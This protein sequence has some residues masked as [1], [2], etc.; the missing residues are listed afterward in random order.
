M[1][2]NAEGG[3]VRRLHRTL[4]AAGLEIAKAE[5]DAEQFGASTAAALGAFQRQRGLR[6]TGE[7]DQITLR[8]LLRIEQTINI[9]IYEGTPAPPP[10]PSQVGTVHGKL[11]EGDGA[12]IAEARISL[13]SVQVRQEQHLADARTDGNGL[14]RMQY[15]RP[16]PLSLV[17]RAL[18]QAGAVIAASQPVFRADADIEVD[19]TTAKDGVVR[20][21]SQFT[22]L[23]SSVK[24]ALKD[25]SLLDLKEN[26]ETHELSFLAQQIGVTFNQLADLYIAESLARD[27]DLRP[28]TLFG[29]FIRGTPPNLQSALNNLP[30]AGIDGAFIAQVFKSV[31]NVRSATLGNTLTA[32]VTAN[33]LPASYADLQS[34]QLARLDAL[35][36]S[37]VGTTPYVRGKTP[38]NDLLHT[39]EVVS[40]VQTAFVQAYAQNSGNLGPTWKALRADK[41]LSKQDLATLN[42]VLS[43]GELLTGNLPL[44]KDTLQRLKQGS[45]TSVRD[46]ALLDEADWEARIR[47]LD[48]GATTIPQVLPNDTP[49]D[50]IARF[51]KALAQRFA[52]RYP[53]TAFVGGMTKA[54]TSSFRQ[55]S[56]LV[57]FLGANATFSFRKSNIDQFIAS[58]KLQISAPAL[59]ELK[60]AQRL[61]RLAPHYPAVEALHAA[62]YTSAQSIYFTGRDRF[63]AQMGKPMGSDARARQAYARAQMAY[64]TALSTFGRYTLLSQGPQ[65]AGMATPKPDPQKL[66]SLPDL[67]ALFGSLDYFQSEDCQSVYS[68]AAY[69]VDLLQ[70]ISWFS[71]TPLPGS[72]PPVSTIANA[73][74]AVLLRRPDIEHVALSCNNTNVVIPYIDLVNEILESAVAPSAIARPT[75]VD[76]QGTTAE[77]RAL[78]QQTQP[79]VAAAAYQATGSVIFPLGLPF[80]LDFARTTAYV[81]GLGTS[82]AALL[83]LFPPAASATAVACANLKINPA[84]QAVIDSADAATPWVR[85]GFAQHP[86]SV[87]DPK[88]GEAYSPNPADWVATL[89]KVPVLLNRSSL[90]LQQLYQLLEVIWVTRSAVTLQAG[91]TTIAGVQVLSADTDAM[92]FTGL[93]AGVLDRANRFLRLWNVTGLKMWELDWALGQVPGGQLDDAFFD[94]L[95][96]AIT[97][98]QR[99]NLPFQ[100]ILTFW[101]PIET[102]SVTSHLGDED[103]AVPATYFETFASP[104]LL[105]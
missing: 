64:A 83:S 52:G 61:H 57:S 100:E 92:V 104:T 35:R 55:K 91:T 30:D 20:A 93:D 62:G 89:N 88:T 34:G 71:A 31:L 4:I 47:A 87:I 103:V 17:V 1:T 3:D 13:F 39:G 54:T 48:P 78:P 16:Q 26:K 59:A 82:R 99:L 94:F 53:T 85:W 46:L 101:A 49:A 19:L 79:A 18:D 37:A 72:T 44:V 23:T 90:S 96:G 95:S 77:R 80:D 84:L 56:E 27:K 14:Y 74:D 15:Q 75:M 97:V 32:A 12:P 10:A 33:V 63:L 6:E 41:S 5:L 21:P 36:V 38:L 105:A 9:T 11:V 69:L 98:Q 45:L 25:E 29:V 24:S 2:L 50:R 22:S 68:P 43:A 58:K 67:Q 102:R 81:T 8:E 66:S 40:N 42:T 65:M 60:T 70:Y 28:E 51:A 7:I 86:A 73:R 76:T